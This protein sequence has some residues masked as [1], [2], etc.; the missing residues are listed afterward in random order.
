[1]TNERKEKQGSIMGIISLAV[2]CLDLAIQASAQDQGTAREV[3][4]R[5]EELRARSEKVAVSIEKYADQ[6]ERTDHSLTD[7]GRSDHRL[8]D[9]YVS[10]SR[11]LLVLENLQRRAATDIEK[12]TAAGTRYFNTWGEADI[13]IEDREL[14]EASSAR[15]SRAMSKYKLLLDRVNEASF[16]LSPM[17]SRFHDLDT[18]FGTELSGDN[19]DTAS[20]VIKAC[21]ADTQELKQQIS[22]L[23]KELGRII[24]ESPG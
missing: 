19:V 24:N 4:K 21:H 14:R 2:L 18:F 23:Q 3:F 22:D 9:R 16:A 11:N 8:H 17:M 10:F 5:S 1:M 7:L 6:L 13:R 12:M 20:D 15:R